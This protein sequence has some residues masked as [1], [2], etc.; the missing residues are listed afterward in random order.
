MRPLSGL[1]SG[2]LAAGLKAARVR[3][4][5]IAYADRYLYRRQNTGTVS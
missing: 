1:V 5:A 2:A 3:G 4:E